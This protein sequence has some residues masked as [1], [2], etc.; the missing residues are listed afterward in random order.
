MHLSD[1]DMPFP[2]SHDVTVDLETL[3]SELHLLLPRDFVVMVELWVLL[4]TLSK[5][6]GEVLF[7]FYQQLGK[8]PTLTQFE[9]L[10]A[11]LHAF[12]IPEIQSADPSSLATFNFYHL[13]LHLQ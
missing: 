2:E 5:V 11:Q 3:P 6:L 4:I 10:E 12:V 1:C 8:R 7:L 9:D 13:Q